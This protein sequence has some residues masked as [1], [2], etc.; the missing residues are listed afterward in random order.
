VKPSDSRDA[1]EAHVR[2]LGLT[3]SSL[4]PEDAVRLMGSFYIDQRAEGCRL[5]EQGDM[6][7]YQW[8]TYT[9]DA[10]ETFQLDL[11][12]QFIEDVG[13]EDPDM[14]Q[15]SL[16]IHYPPAPQF[17]ALGSGNKWCEH[18]NRLTEFESF[19][20]TSEAFRESAKGRPTR[21]SLHWGP[22]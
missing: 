19:I 3:V 7:P 22:V 21:V 15:L 20:R 6:L 18:P 12:R 11:T 4:Q 17:Q 16:T 5:E 13:E 10:P 14:S 2:K 8:G 9:F 1:F